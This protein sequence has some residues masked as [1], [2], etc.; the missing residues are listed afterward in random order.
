MYIKFFLKVQYTHDNMNI[1]KLTLNSFQFQTFPCRICIKRFLA[2]TYRLQI[3][4]GAVKKN[5]CYI[6]KFISSHFY[7]LATLPSFHDIETAA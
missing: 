7:N 6:R 4:D 2:Q 5:Y 1:N 3:K